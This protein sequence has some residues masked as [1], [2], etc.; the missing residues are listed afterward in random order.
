MFACTECDA[1][2]RATWQERGGRG[3][4][5]APGG[6]SDLCYLCVWDQTRAALREAAGLE[7]QDGP[8][9]AWAVARPPEGGA[10]RAGKGP[11][12]GVGGSFPS[13]LGRRDRLA[14][15][16][17]EGRRIL[18]WAN[19]ALPEGADVRVYDV[20]RGEGKFL[21]SQEQFA[22]AAAQELRAAQ[23]RLKADS[24]PAATLAQTPPAERVLSLRD[25]VFEVCAPLLCGGKLL[26]TTS[27]SEKESA[28]SLGLEE[29]ARRLQARYESL[30]GLAAEPDW[31]SAISQSPPLTP[32]QR[33]Y[34]VRA[35]ESL[36]A[37][38]P[39]VSCELLRKA[40]TL[41]EGM[42]RAER[43]ERA[44]GANRKPKGFA[45]R[46]ET[47]GL[48]V[49]CPCGV[50]WPKKKNPPRGRVVTLDA[51]NPRRE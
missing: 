41:R 13:N 23:E 11:R 33:L 21:L 18:G 42:Q 24:G 5:P 15:A 38:G 35:L 32:E 1:E 43:L 30:W 6:G 44:A 37:Q 28:P 8:M 39:M 3:A 9:Q 26:P 7:A 36:Q 50:T 2:H 49:P 22:Q 51:K 19:W 25:W 12:P 47:C 48:L 46:C 34:L 10:R 16:V 20:E 27:T 29:E 40:R 17:E 4:V 31:Q 14:A 45:M